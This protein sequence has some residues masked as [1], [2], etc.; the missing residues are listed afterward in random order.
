MSAAR[1]FRA[2]P[3]GAPGVTPQ[4]LGIPTAAYPGRVA[5]NSD[6]IVAVDRQQ[7]KLLLPLG[8][9]DTTMTVLDPS[10]IVAY[11]LLSID[12]EIVKTTGA[13]AGNVIPISRGFDGTIPAAHASGALVSGLIDA[14]HHNRL[15]SEIEA[16]ETALGP[17]LSLVNASS[18]PFLVS[19]AFQFVPQ[20]PGVS[21]APGN[22]SITLSP[23]PN[24]V[25]GTDQF[26]YLYISGGAGA[27]EAVLITGGSAVS[28]A[29]SGTL[30]L[31]CANAH[32]GAWTI[33]SATSGIQE[34]LVAST[35]QGVGIVFVSAGSH[36]M[37]ATISVPNTTRLTGAGA[38]SVLIPSSPSSTVIFVRGGFG[39]ITKVTI[40]NLA[41]D[42]HA[43]LSNT[44]KGVYIPGGSSEVRV[45]DCYFYDIN[46]T[47][48]ADATLNTI[49]DISVSDINAIDSCGLYF[50]DTSGTNYVMF[51]SVTN[52]HANV[53]ATPTF[54]DAMFVC[55]RCVDV[56]FDN[57][58]VSQMAYAKNFFRMSNDC[59][60]CTISNTTAVAVLNGI[61]L[62]QNTIGASNRGP[63]FTRL[64]N[65]EIDQPVNYGFDLQSSL[66]AQIIGCAVTTMNARTPVAGVHITAGTLGT[67]I[68]GFVAQGIAGTSCGVLTDANSQQWQVSD[69][70]FLTGPAGTTQI[71][72]QVG[73]GSNV[74]QITN[75]IFEG[76]VS[77]VDPTLQGAA[78][79]VTGNIGNG[80]L[81][82][83]LGIPI[84]SAASITLTS[85]SH[86]ISGTAAISTIT[87][88]SG[89][90]GRSVAL[91]PVGAFTT[92]TTGN[93]G[94]ATT[95]VYGKVLYMWW[96]NVKWW[97]S[98]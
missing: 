20:T 62:S 18:L 84:S 1:T 25:N 9:A 94:L 80:L 93:I 10:M 17:N 86:Y 16:I 58:H 67:Q 28:G 54:T 21:L 92:T 7:T 12:N 83:G 29:P 79:T 2:T 63:S 47:V 98:Y 76:V 32:S 38:S 72:I 73:A 68:V 52:W 87:A 3:F 4:S 22:N 27:A 53:N 46:W 91:L 65:V 26:H 11:S 85:E 31:N 74:F 49:V 43:N 15:A 42:G 60:G 69:S 89:F 36:Q 44:N 34:A 14:Y 8:T 37:Y 66:A 45:R 23:V 82:P 48:Y 59:Q 6:L 88:P 41:L 5:T 57:V 95:A 35:S 51:S 96:D 71:G 56:V 77:I 78:K 90:M 39:A 19:N 97:P 33:Q 64:I 13:P 40:D 70:Y 30:I 24:G 50:G 75:N 61:T 81:A 55:E